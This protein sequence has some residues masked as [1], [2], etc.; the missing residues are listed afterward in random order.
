[1]NSV[2]VWGCMESLAAMLESLT[3]RE[4]E[5]MMDGWMEEGGMEQINGTSWGLSV[6][7]AQLL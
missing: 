1:M 7:A 5:Q 2:F 6:E 3:E 4:R